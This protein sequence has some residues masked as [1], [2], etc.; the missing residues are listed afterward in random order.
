MVNI[1]A[2]HKRELE[3]ELREKIQ[4][5]FEANNETPES[6]SITMKLGELGEANSLST[7]DILIKDACAGSTLQTI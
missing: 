7:I 3:T 4:A 1:L 2:A 5:F 6:V